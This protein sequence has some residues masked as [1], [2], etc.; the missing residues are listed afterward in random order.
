VVVLP[1]GL[2]L[3]QTNPT[4]TLEYAPVPPQNEKSPPVGGNFGALGLASSAS[5]NGG[6]VPGGVGSGGPEET[7]TTLPL[8][9]G[10]LVGGG[11]GFKPA[12]TKE[13]VGNPPRQTEDPL[14]PPCV[15]Y[16]QG[17]NFGS[18]YQG[19]TRGEVT[20]LFYMEGFLNDV[21][22]G[23]GPQVTPDHQYIDLAQAPSP[24]DAVE[25]R[26]MRAYMRYFNARYQTYNRFVHF[27]LYFGGADTS[28]E[29][30]QADAID[31]YNHLH[32]FAVLDF[33]PANGPVYLHTMAERGVL[34][35]GSFLGRSQSFY[36]QFPGLIWGYTPTLEES[37]SDYSSFICQKLLP[38]PTTF[39]GGT[40]NG[41]P[42]KFGMVY[43]TDPNHPELT[44]LHQL[45][46]SDLR[47][48]G[49]H[50]AVEH[51]YPEAGYVASTQHPPTYAAPAMADFKTQNV[52][53]I[54]WPGGLETGFSKAAS[55]I[56]YAPEWVVLGDG[57]FDQNDSG[58]FQDQTAWSHAMVVSNVTYQPAFH[59]QIC[60]QV[61]KQ[62][63]P[64]LN[65]ND[66]AYGCQYYVNIRQLL[67][68]IQVAGPRLGPNTIDQGFRAIPQNVS[69][70]N[71][72]VPACFY[73]PGSYTCIKDGVFE[74]W[75][76]QGSS[77][78]SSTPGC[79]MMVEKGQRYLFGQWPPGD[80]TKQENP[81]ADFCNGYDGNY[82]INNNP[83][84]P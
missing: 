54:L 39:A 77:P 55:D 42:R 8:L 72:Q 26:F 6:N 80:P 41:A 21:E 50:V 3:P 1:S 20:V 83:P 35:F 23:N 46:E 67:I 48:C 44:A 36:Q 5:L 52:T 4:Q 7:T 47:Q 64:N 45:V 24:D 57:Q 33:S 43:T 69:S 25:T 34:N 70:T 63:D 84:S 11:V 22:G 29:A 27:W 65:D 16:F 28:A 12:G 56:G 68:G 60:Y 75:N 2:T 78:A 38:N 79:W 13:C 53:T 18:T 9:P 15:A 51:S 40:L 61:E 73:P 76:S 66:A 82:T 81:A 59:D 71:P 74:W 17:D 58:V 31:N 19:V 30:T 49:V 37:A 10:G 32:P 14:S 62:G